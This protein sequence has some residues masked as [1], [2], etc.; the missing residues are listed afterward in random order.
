MDGTLTVAAHDF[1]QIRSQLGIR[2]GLPI[3]EAIAAMPPSEARAMHQRLHEIE[4][5]IA[6]HSKPQSDA[7]ETLESLRQH[8]CEIGILTRNAKDIAEA[9]LSAAGLKQLFDEDVI[10]GRDSCE[11]KPD[12]AGIKMLLKRWEAEPTTAVMVGDYVF[13]LETGRNAGTKTVHFNPNGIFPWPDKTDVGIRKLSE[14][15]EH[16]DLQKS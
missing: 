11:P 12:P 10:I 14:L 8:G 13:D 7:V 4:M 16:L 9:T 2:S 15:T 5:E 3:L 1:D 6:Q